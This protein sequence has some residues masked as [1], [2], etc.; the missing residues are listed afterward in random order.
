[1]NQVKQIQK[2]SNYLQINSG[3]LLDL[4]RAKSVPDW[5]CLECFSKQFP[6]LKLSRTEFLSVRAGMHNNIHWIS[7]EKRLMP[8]YNLGNIFYSK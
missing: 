7:N 8:F 3:G 2:L 5:T 1:M 6:D 4:M